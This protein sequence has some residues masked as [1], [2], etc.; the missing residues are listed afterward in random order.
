[1]KQKG[2]TII[3]IVLM[4]LTMIVI[5]LLFGYWRG[6]APITPEDGPI[7]DVETDIESTQEIVRSS[8]QFAL[9]LYNQYRQQED[10]I[11]FSPYSIVTALAMT[12]EGAKNQTAE[13]MKLVLH[14]PDEETRGKGFAGLYNIFNQSKSDYILKTVNVLWPQEDYNFLTEYFSVIEKYYR[15]K[16]TS[17]NFRDDPEGSRLT[18]NQWV[19]D[20]TEEKIKDLIP[21]G[22]I[23]PITR[24]VLTNAIYFKGTW[25]EGFDSDLTQESDFY[26]DESEKVAVSMMQRIGEEPLRYAEIDDVQILSLPYKGEELAMLIL[27]PKQNEIG[28]LE[29]SLILEKLETYRQSLQPREI[30]LFLP[31]FKLETKYFMKED[32]AEMGMPIAFSMDADFSGMTGNKDLFISE[33]IHQ[34]FV[35]VNEEGTEAAAATAVIMKESAMMIDKPVF[36]AD[37][38]FFFLIEHSETGAILF[39][40]RVNNPS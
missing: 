39:M 7:L 13:E 28:Q 34:A 5:V 19:E 16:A 31:R 15:G 22:F 37:R 17:L 38:P 35:E 27:L 1:M 10:N 26:L 4:I 24:L 11:F 18:I 2:K 25:L 30:D 6:E 21:A 32:L 29:E 36:R 9:D 8:N 20:Q 14:L 33:V 40:G 3:N 12:Y 23:D